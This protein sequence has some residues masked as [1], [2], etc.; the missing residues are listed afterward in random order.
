M[1]TGG[2]ILVQTH[3]TSLFCISRRY[4][5]MHKG[6]THLSRDQTGFPSQST[7]ADSIV[8]AKSTHTHRHTLEQQSRET[9]LSALG[10]RVKLC[11]VFLQ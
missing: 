9:S 3:S 11:S 8:I 10:Y 6:G 2:G 5:S 7:S 4:A 1:P